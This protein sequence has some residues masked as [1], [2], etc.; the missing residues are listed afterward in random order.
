MEE[1]AHKISLLRQEALPDIT[2]LINID[3]KIAEIRKIAEELL[4][5][6][7]YTYPTYPGTT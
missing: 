3:L 2:T 5:Q 6:T 4:F 7:D 1:Q